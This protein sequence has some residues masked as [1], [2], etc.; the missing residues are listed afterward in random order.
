[1]GIKHLIQVLKTH[2]MCPVQIE[3]LHTGSFFSEQQGNLSRSSIDYF[4]FRLT[5][6][7]PAGIRPGTPQLNGV[8]LYH[9]V[10][11]MSHRSQR[12]SLIL[13][14]GWM[15]ADGCLEWHHNTITLFTIFSL[16]MLSKLSNA[17][18]VFQEAD[19]DQH[20]V[21]TQD[22]KTSVCVHC[23]CVVLQQSTQ[24][25]FAGVISMFMAYSG[26]KKLSACY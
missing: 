6:K 11:R 20:S 8:H 7:S 18:N 17:K 3:Q 14:N 21:F 16:V 23:F 9:S 26:P 22:H 25:V 24:S 2:L 13:R 12:C 4:Y 15:G 1:M 19:G 5:Q 10:S